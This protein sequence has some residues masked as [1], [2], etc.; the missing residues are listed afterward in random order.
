MFLRDDAKATGALFLLAIAHDQEGKARIR[1]QI[2]AA[3]S[4][5]D[6]AF[7]FQA[8]KDARKEAGLS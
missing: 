6:L 4:T 7:A 3:H 8:F 1:A 2:S 5:E